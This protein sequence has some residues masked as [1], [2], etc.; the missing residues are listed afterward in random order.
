MAIQNR[1]QTAAAAAGLPTR[2]RPAYL[3]ALLCEVAAL[4]HDDQ[5]GAVVT[6]RHAGDVITLIPLLHDP[7]LGQKG[8]IMDL[9]AEGSR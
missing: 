1:M 8:V 6:A 5:A 9:V 3:V 4:G 2:P 7:F